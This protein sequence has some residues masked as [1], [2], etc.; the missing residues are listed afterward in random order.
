MFRNKRQLQDRSILITGASSGIGAALARQLVRFRPRLL[1]T[2]RRADR[3]AELSKKLQAQG[4]DSFTIAGDITDPS[5]RQ[6]L[7]DTAREQFGGLDVLINNAGVGGI[8]TFSSAEENRL[9]S[10]MEVNFFAPFELIRSGLPLLESSDDGVIVNIGSVLGHFAVPKKSEYCASKFAMHGMTDAI[11]M[12]LGSRGIDV[13][14]VSPSTTS[15]EFFDRAIR[16]TDDTIKNHWAMSPDGVAKSTIW[17]IERR[18]RETI[19]S[20][21]G[22]ALVTANRLCPGLLARVLSRFA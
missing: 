12:E 4:V 7:I 11:R 17:A 2:A 8:G 6:Q 14:L 3:L 19:L 10:I 9:R 15:S 5:L 16:S 20:A 1:L 21:G 22:L 13:L 18:K